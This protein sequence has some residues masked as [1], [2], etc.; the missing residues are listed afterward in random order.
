MITQDGL[1]FVFTAIKNGL[2]KARALVNGQYRD[3][4]LQKVEVGPSSIKIYIY[5]S[6]AIVGQITRYQLLLNDGKVFLERSEHI[7]KDGTRGLL[8]LFEIKLQEV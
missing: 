4:E 7:A 6:E 2:L 1:N 8:T 3:V 5:L